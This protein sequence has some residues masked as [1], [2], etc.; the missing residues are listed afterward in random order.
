MSESIDLRIP[1]EV[2]TPQKTQVSFFVDKELYAA[3]K[4]VLVIEKHSYT[5]YDLVSYM[6]ATVDGSAA[7]KKEIERS[8]KIISINPKLYDRYSTEKPWEAR[9]WCTHHDG[10]SVAISVE[11]R[12]AFDIIVTRINYSYYISVPGYGIALP[13][14]GSIED[15]FWITEKMVA[16]DMP[17]P[18]AITAAQ[19]LA[20]FGNF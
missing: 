6:Q 7:K 4:K 14:I 15:T 2:K 18:D 10:S 19:V 12:S 11:S 8:L 13:N 16:R 20:D 3:Y 17:I 9:Y 5:T 1:E